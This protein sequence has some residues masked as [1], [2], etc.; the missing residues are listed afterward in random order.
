MKRKLPTRGRFRRVQ[1]GLIG[2][3]E[4]ALLGMAMTLALAVLER[5]LSPPRGRTGDKTG[6]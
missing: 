5:R 1:A 4:R 6:R 2:V 3:A